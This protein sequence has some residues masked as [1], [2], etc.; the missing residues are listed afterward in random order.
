MT[1]RTAKVNGQSTSEHRKVWME[2]YGPI[3]DGCVIHHR[4]GRRDDNRLSNLELMTHRQ[5][6]IH[7]NEKHPRTK[8]CEICGT[9]FTPDKTKRKRQQTCSPECR[10]ALQSRRAYAGGGGGCCWWWWWFR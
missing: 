7:H 5:H 6:S 9:T 4:N 1:Y 3:P 10:K 8:D 2:A